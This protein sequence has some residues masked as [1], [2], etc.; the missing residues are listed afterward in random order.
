[1]AISVEQPHDCMISEKGTL[2][3]DGKKIGNLKS[4]TLTHIQVELEK[5]GAIKGDPHWKHVYLKIQLWFSK[6]WKEWLPP[7]HLFPY[8]E[9]DQVQSISSPSGPIRSR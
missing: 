4:M 8:D 6:Q 2:S 7:V 3:I 1:M 9:T 5:I